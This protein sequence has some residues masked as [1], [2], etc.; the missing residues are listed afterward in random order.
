MT[1]L[2]PSVRC[3][4]FHPT[5]GIPCDLQS[6]HVGVH[7][8]STQLRMLSWEAK[9]AA[10]RD[11]C[12]SFHPIH[13]VACEFERG[14][15]SQHAHTIPFSVLRW[16]VKEVPVGAPRTSSPPKA[17]IPP[18]REGS[19]LAHLEK[20]ERVARAAEVVRN[21]LVGTKGPFPPG[22]GLYELENALRDLYS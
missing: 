20:L 17:A 3:E 2:G 13:G 4:S 1:P 9:A 11:R 8:S 12:P 5:E 19:R 10:V 22:L 16:D 7:S 6:G 14:H 15:E 18:G 21:G